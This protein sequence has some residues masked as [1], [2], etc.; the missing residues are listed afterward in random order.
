MLY[1]RL[2]FG[3]PHNK[4]PSILGSIFEGLLGREFCIPRTSAEVTLE[5]LGVL[6]GNPPNER[7]PLISESI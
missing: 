6:F 7:G 5:S 1:P 3:S 2:L 4:D